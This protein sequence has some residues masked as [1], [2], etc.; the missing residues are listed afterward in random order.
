MKSCLWIQF[1]GGPVDVVMPTL[2]TSAHLLAKC[3]VSVESKAHCEWKSA[4]P[5]SHLEKIT[6][7]VCPITLAG[8]KGTLLNCWLFIFS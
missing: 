2:L 5:S 6:Q 3:T 4:N 1:L 8:K 7:H